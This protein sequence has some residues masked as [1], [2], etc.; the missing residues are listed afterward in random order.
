[1]NPID[2]YFKIKSA[3]STESISYTSSI[4]A[5]NYYL[6]FLRT[7]YIV[8]QTSHWKCTGKEFYGNHLMFDGLYT[9]AQKS[10]DK[11]A[12]KIIGNF[13]NEALNHVNQCA[14]IHKLYEGYCSENHLENSLKVEMDF[15]EISEKTYKTLKSGTGLELTLG[16]DDLIMS[17]QEKTE[18]NIYL[19]KQA[20]KS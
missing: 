7:A 19:L 16:I 1:M 3:Q 8:H 2:V 15:K 6:A 13:G 18:T 10:V 11:V 14:L 17:I 12:E 5:L 20:S 4:E 9:K